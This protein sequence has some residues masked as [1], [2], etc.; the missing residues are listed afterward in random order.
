MSEESKQY[1]PL[2]TGE[3]NLPTWKSVVRRSFIMNG[4]WEYLVTDIPEPADPEKLKEWTRDRVQASLILQK[5]LLNPHIER[6]LVNNGL[7]ME[8]D[9]PKAIWDLVNQVVPTVTKASMSSLL[10][11]FT[12]LDR[13]SFATLFDYINKVQEINKRLKSTGCDLQENVIIAITLWGLKSTYP[14]DHSFWIRAFETGTLK[15]AELMK[16]LGRIALD[17]QIRP[18][19]VSLPAKNTGNPQ[20]S[21]QNNDKDG[22]KMKRCTKPGCKF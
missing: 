18:T 1:I 5:S 4:L 10:Y 19:M 11:E 22:G 9:D 7:D 12:R 15:W 3:D 20:G 6:M 13:K 14:N 17:E 8:E 2:L 16:E 21:G